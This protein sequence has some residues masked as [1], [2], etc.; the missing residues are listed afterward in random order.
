MS[1]SFNSM[2]SFTL[3][4]LEEFWTIYLVQW[5]LSYRIFSREDTPLERTQIFG[6]K[7]YDCM[8]CSLSP[9]DTFLI[10]TELSGRRGVLITVGITVIGNWY[11]L[12]SNDR[13]FSGISL[14]TCMP[15]SEPIPPLN[16]IGLIH[17]LL[18]PP[19]KVRPNDRAKPVSSGSPNLFP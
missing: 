19:G 8:Q 1:D 6:S 13:P 18:S 5:S 12:L 7:Y 9:K 15:S 17:S 3:S 2:L 16:M 10:R 14:F 4:K 11:F